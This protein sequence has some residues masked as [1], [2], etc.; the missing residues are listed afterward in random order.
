MKFSLV[1]KIALGLLLAGGP[2]RADMF[3]VPI[4]GENTIT[5]YDQNGNG[6]TFT[7]A[8]VPGPYVIALD[9]EGKVYVTTNN[10]TIEITRDDVRFQE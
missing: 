3:F 5:R 10:N 2:V 7:G 6:S 9:A 1:P 4:S 8:F